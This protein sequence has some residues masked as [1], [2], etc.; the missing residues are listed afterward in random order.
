[1]PGYR[2]HHCT[3]GHVEDRRGLVFPRSCPQCGEVATQARAWRWK[4][5]AN[6]GDGRPRESLGEGCGRVRRIG[7]AE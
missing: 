4:D 1:M 6:D 5:A 7:G 3:C 2:F